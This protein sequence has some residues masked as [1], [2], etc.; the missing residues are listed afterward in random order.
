MKKI[1]FLITIILISI[2][3][4]VTWAQ[5]SIAKQSGTYFERATKALLEDNDEQKA[6]ELL[7]LELNSNPQ[8]GQAWYWKAAIYSN[9]S[10]YGDAL[11]YINK[12]IQC[13]PKSDKAYRAASF[14]IRSSIYLN[15]KDTIKALSD[16]NTAI[17]IDK[18][19]ENYYYTRACL[20]MDKNDYKSAE[21]DFIQILNLNEA[22]SPAYV[23]LGRICYAE[24]RYKE[25]I[26]RFTKAIT[27]HGDYQPAYTWRGTT[28][29]E[30]NDY[31]KATTDIIASLQLGFNLWDY[32]MIQR[33]A[34]VDYDNTITKIRNMASR[35][36]SDDIWYH[37]L[38]EIYEDKGQYAN[39]IEAFKS[40][41]DVEKDT[42]FFAKIAD[43]FTTIGN[44]SC[45]LKY[46]DDAIIVNRESVLLYVKR[47]TIK[48]YMGDYKGALKDI[49]NAMNLPIDENRYYIYY[50]RG[51]IKE[52]N[53]QTKE[54][55]K[56]YAQAISS[57]DQYA[58]AYL[59][60]GR[61]RYEMGFI[62][63]AMKDFR[64]VLE[65]E[66]DSSRYESKPF[67]Y[68]YLGR[69][70]EAK[71]TMNIMLRQGEH[72][73][74]AA[75][76][77]SLLRDEET[78]LKYFEAA[79]QNGSR[80]FAHIKRDSDLDFIRYTAKYKHLIEKYQGL[81]LV[82][83][84]E[85]APLIEQTTSELIEPDSTVSDTDF[86]RNAS[87]I[88]FT[89]TGG[90]Y[91]VKCK[92]NGLP[93]D[94]IFDTGASDV[95]I[96]SKE[97]TQ[98]FKEGYLTSRDIQGERQYRTASGDI[99]VGTLVNIKKIEIGGFTLHNVVASVV[100]NENAPALLGQSVLSRL[101]KIEID[102]D[103]RV[104]I[105]RES[106]EEDSPTKKQIEKDDTETA[107]AKQARKEL[108][109]LLRRAQDDPRRKKGQIDHDDLMYDCVD[110]IKAMAFFKLYIAE[111]VESENREIQKTI[112]LF[113]AAMNII[114]E[115][116]EAITKRIDFS[117]I[118]K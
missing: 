48:N 106:G 116:K 74:N 30:M 35:D 108:L 49:E 89:K 47:A 104:I 76:L 109:D 88:P 3:S 65:L 42:Y 115:Y 18:N 33:I 84:C 29:F 9:H 51:W 20:H 112:R 60:L 98:L 34:S 44:F 110:A 32:W 92:I 97:A 7:N 38:G 56:D 71:E 43:C 95:S 118:I 64:R 22:S 50:M 11:G 114:D 12:A 31:Y 81:P 69:N 41:Y 79:L 91:K 13:L 90:V 46:I 99:S 59:K 17:K 68:Y 66:V 40:A 52:Y 80:N 63:E 100:N 57:N 85:K 6:D 21:K 101:G 72:S 111:D 14:Q 39:A 105:L 54:A 94:F 55:M 53:N 16:I 87:E 28:Y 23:G 24:K 73:Y 102:Y 37:I 113:H 27:L 117:S 86:R 58:V 45:A 15:I 1:Y 4:N 93:L 36:Q 26:T 61:L 78:S 77:Y 83:D 5:N 103:R 70:R 19:N 96:S 82:G 75:C 2:T 25:A 8:N 62:D 67:A 107:T 10:E